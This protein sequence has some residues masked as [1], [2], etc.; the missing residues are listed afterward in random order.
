MSTNECICFAL[1][2]EYMHMKNTFAFDVYM[3]RVIFLIFNTNNIFFT[4]FCLPTKVSY[5][6]PI[7]I[8]WINQVACLN[9]KQSVVS[10]N[11]IKGSRCCFSTLPSM[12]TTVWFQ[13]RI[14]AWFT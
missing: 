14:R 9:R 2:E 4:C 8:V 7:T 13:E 6:T 12:I 10:S 1:Q 11:L 3:I 5:F